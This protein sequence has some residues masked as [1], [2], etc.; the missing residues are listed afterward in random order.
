M[1]G[2]RVQPEPLLQVPRCAGFLFASSVDSPSSTA[3]SRVFEAQKPMPTCMM[4]SGLGGGSVAMPIPF[5]CCR[6][7]AKLKIILAYR[8]AVA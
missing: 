1:R 5:Y 7:G 2:P 4:W 3:L 6:T 8:Q